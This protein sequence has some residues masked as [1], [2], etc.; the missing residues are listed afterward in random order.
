MLKRSFIY[1][2][3]LALLVAANCCVVMEYAHAS[4]HATAGDSCHTCG[5]TVASHN[6][7]ES[8]HLTACSGPLLALSEKRVQ[9]P[10]DNLEIHL[11]APSP[12][13]ISFLP[14]QAGSISMGLAL[15]SSPPLE[16]LFQMLVS[17]TR[18]AI[19]PPTLSL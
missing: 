3:T 12:A 5:D 15:E 11:F 2:I 8:C 19:A 1:V 16:E 9:E 17:L 6:S 10:G 7:H 18:A 13:L 14:P 4:I